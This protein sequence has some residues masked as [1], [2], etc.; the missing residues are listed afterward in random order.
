MEWA[1]EAVL[2]LWQADNGLKVVKWLHAHAANDTL[3][4]ASISAHKRGAPLCVVQ[5]AVCKAI[6]KNSHGVVEGLA[7]GLENPFTQLLH[8]LVVSRGKHRSMTPCNIT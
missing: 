6:A 4:K 7:R 2:P 1:L 5:E 3:F 8:T